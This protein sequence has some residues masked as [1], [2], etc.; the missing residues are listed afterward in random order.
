MSCYYLYQVVMLNFWAVDLVK[1]A[2]H[3]YRSN[4]IF[5]SCNHPIYQCPVNTNSHF[6]LGTVKQHK[7]QIIIDTDNNTT[8]SCDQ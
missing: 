2:L 8:T 3:F 1:L 5:V 7:M 4:L 6:Y